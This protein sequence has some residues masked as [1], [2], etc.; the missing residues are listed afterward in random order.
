MAVSAL[1]RGINVPR[2]ACLFRGKCDESLFF[3]RKGPDRALPLEIFNFP[4]L[5]PSQ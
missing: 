2:I 4:S 5:L 3:Q 1:V